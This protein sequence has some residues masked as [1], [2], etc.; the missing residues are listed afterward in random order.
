MG[1]ASVECASAFSGRADKVRINT[2]TSASRRGRILS[3]LSGEI[4]DGFVW[5]RRTRGLGVFH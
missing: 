5:C 2:S 1:V 4:P 3:D